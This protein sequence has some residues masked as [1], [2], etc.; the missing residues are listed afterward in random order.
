MFRR[1]MYSLEKVMNW[2]RIEGNWSELK[3]QAKR[4]F[5]KLIDDHTK[6]IDGK[7]E[8]LAAKIQQVHSIVQNEAEQQINDFT[9]SRHKSPRNNFYKKQL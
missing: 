9:Q 2:N 8:H 6:H 5:G 1:V 3:G 4:N 7:R